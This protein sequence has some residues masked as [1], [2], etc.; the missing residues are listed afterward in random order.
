MKTIRKIA[1]KVLAALMLF[2][3]LSV[4]ALA[5]GTVTINLSQAGGYAGDS[6]TI[7]GTAD[8]NQWVSI[9]AMDADGNIVYF[10]AACC[11]AAGDYTNTWTVPDITPGS[12]E[13]TVGYGSVV[14]S[15]TF[16]VLKRQ[17][18]PGGKT[19]DEDQEDGDTEDGDTND[20]EDETITGTV[21][22]TEDGYD[23]TINGDDFAA[24]TGGSVKIATEFVEITFD[25]TAAKFI[26]DTAGSGN[27]V[28]SVVNAD[29]SALSGKA[30]ELIG[31]RPAYEFFLSAGGTDLSTFGGGLA[32]VSI[33][34]TPG[35]NEDV[36]RIV[37]YFISDDGKLIVMTDSSYDGTSINAKFS[38][39]HFS[40]YAVGYTEVTF[41]DVSEGDWYY[42]AVTFCAAREITTGT[43]NN[44]FSPNATLTRSQ[45]IV[46]LMRAYGLQADAYSADNFDD[47][48]DTYYT[49][50]LS[51]AKRLGIT[52][53][54]G[55]NLFAPESK[56][57]R[58]DMFTLLYRALDA[59]GEWPEADGAGALSDFSDEDR[60]ADYAEQAMD[61]LYKAGVV[62]GSNG[63][64][65][66]LG[67]STR[68]QMAQVLYKLLSL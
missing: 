28:L 8:P 2:S 38:T 42:D 21:D 67:N 68:A 5:V 37:I 47:A 58:Q 40:V 19:G 48:G 54:I 55:N 65:D 14:A 12:L 62:S 39:G 60:I 9:K 50:Y 66:P 43:G 22:D 24:A 57:T 15:E 27:I 52:N 35:S 6:V 53:G 23:I 1:V 64:L 7:S 44:L 18:Y 3:L 49:G 13:I 41:N 56:I 11:D 20:S 34:Y 25:Q 16:M 26:S 30:Q 4:P 33:P 32:Y 61:M 29:K 51:A 31:D 45:F 10:S 63:Q 59:L 46:M 17:S 36:N